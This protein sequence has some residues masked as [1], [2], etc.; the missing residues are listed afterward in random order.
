M[1]EIKIVHENAPGALWELSA[2]ARGLLPQPAATVQATEAALDAVT[3][4]PAPAETQAPP[5]AAEAPKRSRGRPAKDVATPAPTDAP[6]AATAAPPAD[7][8]ALATDKT[9]EVV[10]TVAE[11]AQG[12]IRL[13]DAQPTR[14]ALTALAEANK[15]TIGR[16]NRE[17]EGRL[18]DVEKAY[19][20]KSTA[21]EQAEKAAASVPPEAPAARP[22]V[23]LDQAR[24]ALKLVADA[25]GFENAR[26]IIV[27]YGVAKVSEVPDDKRADF[28]ADCRAELTAN[29][30]ADEHKAEFAR[31]FGAP[32]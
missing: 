14:A 8:Y 10:A 25:V 4:T 19:N 28:F 5:E 9:S 23:T 22:A 24:E 27:K 13:I 11:W 32:A 30:V 26:L 15:D 16:I 29:G 18:G 3:A 7:G 6:P 1:I 20:A 17:Q 21:L 31:I 12:M 2:L